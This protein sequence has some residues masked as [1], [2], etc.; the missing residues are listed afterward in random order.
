MSLIVFELS[1][2][3][4][5]EAEELLRAACAYDR[6]GDVA[7]EK[8]FG[9][10]PHGPTVALGAF[11]G[12]LLVGVAAV[13]ARWLRLLAVHPAH[14]GRGAGTRLLAE[15]E[16]RAPGRLR[17]CD[18][19]GNYLAPGIDAR[20]EETIGWLERRGYRHAGENENLA[21]PLLGNPRV[22]A[23]PR[24]AP[25]G[26]EVLRAGPDDAGALAAFAGGFGKAWAF[27]AARAMEND[28]PGVHLALRD[29]E[30]VA[31]ACH[32]GNNRGLGWFGPAGTAEAHRGQGLGEALLVPCL[33][34]I[35]ATGHAEGTIAWI[36]P[37]RFY[38]EK[39][40]ARADRRFVVLEK[41]LSPRAEASDDATLERGA[42]ERPGAASRR[43]RA[44]P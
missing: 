19:P 24:P 13:S 25:P 36:G 6:A 3:R 31:F 42:A 40:G 27:E 28:P 20:D 43:E 2:P 44:K 22:S 33:L 8:L 41:I 37:R 16:A 29:G 30:I 35:A 34:D 23:R 7:A 4:L 17:T 38:E 14:R 26:Y 39:V 9:A 15:A 1:R 11:D 10:A 12:D 32:D 5:A 18:Q 21:V